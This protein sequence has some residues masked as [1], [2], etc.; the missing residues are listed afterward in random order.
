[1]P[2]NPAEFALGTPVHLNFRKWDDREHWQ[3]DG[4]LLGEDE[5]GVW[6]GF[7]AGSRHYR[8]GH[9]FNASRDHVIL[10]PSA[11]GWCA[12][13]YGDADPDRIKIYIDLSSTTTWTAPEEGLLATLIDLD[14]DVIER[15]NGFVFIDDEDEFLDHQVVFG[16]PPQVIAQ[17]RANA[18]ALLEEVRAHWPPFD[19]TTIGHWLGKLRSL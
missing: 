8:P 18:D 4:Y 17:V 15:G 11:A 19:N 2:V 14:L 16:Y 9:S 13:L 12:M 3:S 1:M 7:R 10:V 6:L 5:Y